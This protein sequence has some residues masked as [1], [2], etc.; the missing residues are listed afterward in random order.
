MSKPRR[1]LETLKPENYRLDLK[2]DK[3]NLKF[4]GSVIIKAKLTRP[5]TS[6]RLHAK[7]LKIKK[8]MLNGQ[9]A[10][11]KID[12]SRDEVIL[13]TKSQMSGQLTIVID[14]SGDITDQTHGIYPSRCLVD[15]K[16]EIVL[17]TQFESH[18]AREVFPCIDEPAAKATFDL[19]LETEPGEVVLANTP[20]KK[21]TTS[22]QKLTT[23]FETTPI[24]STYLLA[25]VSGNLKSVSRKTKTGVL[26]RAWAIPTKVQQ[27]KFALDVCVR[28]LEFFEDYFDTPYPLAKCD[29]VALPEFASGAMENWGLITF[30]E[31][32]L[33]VDPKTTSIDYKQYVA[34]VVAHELAHQWFG[35]LVTMSWWTDLWLNEGFATW[36][37]YLAVDEFFPDWQIWE[38]FVS[39]TYL[40]AQSLDS[41]EHT[42]PI[43][44][45]I[46]S[47]EEI[48]TI[49]DSI[50]YNKGASIIRMLQS[51]LG[52][53]PF[54]KGLVEYLHRHAYGNATTS[55]LWQA[56]SD[57]SK[58]PVAKFMDAWTTQ[59]GYPLL[60]VNKS[61]SG[62]K[63][64]Q[65]RYVIN[66]KVRA[67]TKS[68]K[69][70]IPIHHNGKIKL[71]EDS[72]ELPADTDIAELNPARSGFYM[73]DYD[74]Q[75]QT[76][77][78][79]LPSLDSLERLGLL[80]D[81]WQLAKGGFSSTKNALDL[82]LSYKNESSLVVWE[83]LSYQLGSLIRVFGDG[84]TRE[85][86][87]KLASDLVSPQLKRLGWQP[88]KLESHADRLLRP[89]VLGLG[90]FAREPLVMEKSMK[91][92]ADAKKLSDLPSDL[93]NVILAGVV[94]QS[95]P[96]IF[97]KL[98]KW[99]SQTESSEEKNALAA[100]MTSFKQKETI[101]QALSLIRTD[102][103]RLQDK[104]SWVA[105]LF[106][107][108]FAIDD[109]WL[110]LQK[111]WSWLEE[112]LGDDM[113]FSRLPNVVGRAFK[114]PAHL[115]T[116]QS[117][118]AK[119]SGPG[120]TR[121]IAQG[122]E[123]IEWQSAWLTRDQKTVENWL[124][125]QSFKP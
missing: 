48:R 55:D 2:L 70:P 45:E 73:L 57:V 110:W 64:S 12:E 18:H 37:E 125:Y 75:V 98:L 99:H 44:V 109:S 94:K 54:R 93:R 6:V 13:T 36:I 29:L 7:D 40:G 87:R 119:I 1:L 39:D 21:Q 102:E 38:Q 23:I 114:T 52:A 90:V 4:S 108:R 69:W 120:L 115:K 22:N 60:T 107:N 28:S 3:K 41:L 79:R 84:Q 16:S 34:M 27:L 76:L 56:L 32:T 65:Q 8:T 35:N 24:M 19:I 97:D 92:F 100:A 91:F 63:L 121:S 113:S 82:T 81:T 26:V 80:N 74:N 83:V 103:V 20:I 111:N 78:D 89:L 15:G 5:S 122:Q 105:N 59:P 53:E 116:Y 117:F 17:G 95:G 47:P 43:Q 62:Y 51:Y 30:R 67:S 25:F 124:K 88:K 31:V 86:M 46:G 68:S 58:K 11:I 10:K 123:V 9:L 14:F 66:P 77:A 104:L 85:Q 50:S 96:A 71:V 112:L 118:F 61:D 49:F 101:H 72:L 42:H 33:L 106:A